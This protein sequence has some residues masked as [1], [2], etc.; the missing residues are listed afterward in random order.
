MADQ[1]GR[2]GTRWNGME[3][4]EVKICAMITMRSNYHLELMDKASL[5]FAGNIFDDMTEND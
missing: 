5:E 3:A 2:Q 1:C 4:T